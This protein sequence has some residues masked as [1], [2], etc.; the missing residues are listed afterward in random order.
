MKRVLNLEGYRVLDKLSRGF[1]EQDYPRDMEEYEEY[2]KRNPRLELEDPMAPFE[3]WD[4]EARAWVEITRMRRKGKL[5]TRLRNGRER[6]D[7]VQ[8]EGLSKR[9]GVSKEK[10]VSWLLGGSVPYLIRKIGREI[11]RSSTEVSEE[12]TMA[13]RLNMWIPEVNGVRIQSIE[14]LEELVRERFPSFLKRKDYPRFIRQAALHLKLVERFR[15]E[16]LKRGDIASIARETGEFPTTI[17]RW[18]IE[19]AK[20]RIYHYLTR[21]PLD[22]REQRVARILSSLNGVTDMGK[23]EQR[24]RTLFLY[25]TLEQSTGHQ[26]NLERAQL[27]FQFLEEYTKGGIL[28]SIAKRMKIGKSTVSEWFS[29]SQQP[30]YIRLAVTVPEAP[31][32][33]GKKWLPLRLNSRTNL[34]EQFI[35][36]PEVVKSEEDILSVLRQLQSLDAPQEKEFEEMHDRESTPLTFMYLIGLMVSDGG[37]DAD[38]DLSARV[39]LFASKKYQWSFNLG[40]AFAFAMGRIGLEVEKRTDVTKVKD[41]KTTTFYVW[42]SQASPFL[43]WVKEVLFGLGRS[44]KKKGIPIRAEWVLNMPHDHRVAFLQGL[45]DGDGY[46]SIKAFRVGIGSKTNQD[47]IRKLLS[48]FEIQSVMEKTK[49]VIKKHEHIRKANSLPLFKHAL[50]RKKSHDEL[51]KIMDL[52]DG[53]GG[54]VP[55]IERKIILELHKQGFT[56][57]EIAEKLWHDYG[58]AR[59][60]RSV[61]G[62]VQRHKK[63]S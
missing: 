35:Q 36:V 58:Y 57:G 40:Q 2:L 55:E 16:V 60:M 22:D 15:N 29:G 30:T 56:P 20:P 8:I 62:I 19:G 39:V 44:D 41:G 45:A 9:Y 27:F 46:A 11:V 1:R 32:E 24:L 18:L 31:P 21:N 42:A 43:R 10:I 13:S 63:K 53:G 14:Q 34:P 37:F 17:K 38:S 23:L 26:E 25:E 5:K 61:Y 51:C 48:T 52:L 33:P 47:F 50:S 7:R 4:R 12:N 6:Y 59:S 28:K 49:V 3:E 54:R